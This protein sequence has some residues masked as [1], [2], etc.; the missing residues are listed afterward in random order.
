MSVA[1]EE[2]WQALKGVLGHPAWANEPSLATA[3]GRH[4]S[5]DQIDKHLEQWSRTQSLEDAVEA[6]VG[7]G[8]PAAPLRD[9]RIISTHPQMVA[10]SH[11]ETLDHPVLGPHTLPAF[12][13]KFASVDRWHRSP[14]PLL[15]QHN[16]EILSRLLSLDPATIERLAADNI[17]GMRPV[18]ID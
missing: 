4:Q 1:D 6:L 15:G 3:S 18:G 13:F 11:F 12:P 14:A 10:R 16:T 8:I 7:R 2:Q 9:P 17:V 5:H